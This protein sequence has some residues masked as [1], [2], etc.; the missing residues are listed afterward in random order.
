L[1]FVFVRILFCVAYC[2]RHHCHQGLP[3]AAVAA[4]RA[5]KAAEK[6]D[7]RDGTGTGTGSGAGARRGDG[8]LLAGT[9]VRSGPALAAAAGGGGAGRGGRPAEWQVGLAEGSVVTFRLRIRTP[10]SIRTAAS[11]VEVRTADM[12]GGTID[13]PSFLPMTNITAGDIGYG[14]G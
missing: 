5:A 6:T 7:R 13:G 4:E 3:P 8:R 11:S 12:V 1:F 10:P 14:G 9:V 2:H